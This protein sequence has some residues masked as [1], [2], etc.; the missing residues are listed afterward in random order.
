MP[1]QL[2]E[3]EPVIARSS[4]T[5]AKRSGLCERQCFLKNDFGKG[6]FLIRLQMTESDR[7]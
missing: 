1:V 2:M 4:V 5:S 7:G 6:I 3:T